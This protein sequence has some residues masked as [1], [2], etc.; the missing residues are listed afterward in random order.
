MKAEELRLKGNG[1]KASDADRIH[2]LESAL[3]SA[4]KAKQVL[5]EKLADRSLDR[6]SFKMRKAEQDELITDLE[7]KISDAKMAQR[8]VADEHNEAKEKIETAKSFLDLKSMTEEAWEKFIDDV[9][10]YPDY[11]MEIHWSFEEA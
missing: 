8:L 10:V 7:Q 2:T 5:F 3:E 4:K 9:I 1:K 6:E 11:R